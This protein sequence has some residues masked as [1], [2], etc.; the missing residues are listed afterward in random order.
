MEISE[1]QAVEWNAIRH[2]RRRHDG[3]QASPRHEIAKESRPARVV[4]V[5]FLRK[6]EISDRERPRIEADTESS[7][8]VK[9]ANHQPGAREKHQRESGFQGHQ[10]LPAAQAR[11]RSAPCAA[12]LQCAIEIEA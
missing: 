10:E 7:K 5:A 6:L 4:G 12:V 11:R 8:L 2:G 3:V 1:G 9:A